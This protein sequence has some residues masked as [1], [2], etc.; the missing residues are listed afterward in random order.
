MVFFLAMSIRITCQFPDHPFLSTIRSSQFSPVPVPGLVPAGPAV[1]DS[2]GPL[3]VS[4][5]P[6][7]EPTGASVD[8][9][10]SDTPLPDDPLHRSTPLKEMDVKVGSV[11][12]A[13]LSWNPCSR[14][15][16]AVFPEKY[17]GLWRVKVVPEPVS[18]P[19]QKLRLVTGRSVVK[20]M[21]YWDTSEARRIL[22][23]PCGESRY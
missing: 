16:P 4:P 19:S 7:V 6:S 13:K 12:P 3:V 15:S 21:V 17:E 20:V 8:P 22:S 14:Y 9:T 23:F 2:W 18:W 5:G 10:G 11:L 1:V